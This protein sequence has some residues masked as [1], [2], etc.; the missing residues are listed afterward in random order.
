MPCNTLAGSRP[1]ESVG[2]NPAKPSRKTAMTIRP[3]IAAGSV[4]VDGASRPLSGWTAAASPRQDAAGRAAPRPQIR[5]RT[6]APRP[7]WNCWR[8]AAAGKNR[9]RGESDRASDPSRGGDRLRSYRR[10]VARRICL[11][12]DFP[13]VPIRK[14]QQQGQRRRTA[15]VQTSSLSSCPKYPPCPTAPSLSR[16]SL[17]KRGRVSQFGR[18]E[19]VRQRQPAVDGDRGAGH[20]A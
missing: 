15:G 6:R 10:R 7:R 14:P 12:R 8:N 4:P 9:A 20:I 16:T 13:H 3:V 18:I 1:A 2:P 19:P 5:D 11:H 17:S